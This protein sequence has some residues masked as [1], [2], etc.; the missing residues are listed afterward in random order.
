MEG[1]TNVKIER[2]QVFIYLDID[3]DRKEVGTTVVVRDLFYNQQ[4]RR[5]WSENHV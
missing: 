5:K 1:Q 4:I 2:V 3:D